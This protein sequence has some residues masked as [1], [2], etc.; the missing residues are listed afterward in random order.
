[1]ERESRQGFP[2]LLVEQDANR[3]RGGGD[4]DSQLLRT[5]FAL[6]EGERGQGFPTIYS[7]CYNVH[8][9]QTL[10]VAQNACPPPREKD[11]FPGIIFF[12]DPPPP[13]HPKKTFDISVSRKM[14]KLFFFPPRL[15]KK[16]GSLKEENRDRNR[17]LLCM[18]PLL[19]LL[20]TRKVPTAL[21]VSLS[22]FH[23]YSRALMQ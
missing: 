1:M 6:K 23:C 20:P 21:S 12:K 7:H 3:E 8:V 19:L 22:C 13:P 9:P 11:V 2:T 17:D 16:N 4:R 14:L 15:Q 10:L 5:N 18:L